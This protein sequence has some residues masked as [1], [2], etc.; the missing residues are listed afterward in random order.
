MKWLPLAAFLCTLS[1]FQQPCLAA[2]PPTPEQ[3]LKTL[4]EKD[5]KFDNVHLEYIDS[6]Q[7]LYQPSTS[8]FSR[9]GPPTSIPAPYIFEHR[10]NKS[11]ILRGKQ[12]TM[13]STADA[14]L[15]K[16]QLEAARASIGLYSK[17]ST[18]D[19]TS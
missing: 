6:G 13:I 2:D 18:A 1:L 7:R 9:N 11:L 8:G 14:E 17:F 3:I 4:R 5:A 19:G 10:Y 16:K 15:R 12:V